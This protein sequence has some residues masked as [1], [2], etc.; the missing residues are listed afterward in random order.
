MASSP[1]WAN[2]VFVVTYDE[3]GGFFDHVAPPRSVAANTVDPPDT[4]GEVLLGMR[5]P[6]IVASPWSRAGAAPRVSSE[7]Y[8]H[9]SILKLIEWRWG[10]P[11]LTAR[12]A[13]G[14]NITNLAHALDLAH[15]DPVVPALPL[16]ATPILAACPPPVAPHDNPWAALQASSLMRRGW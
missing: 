13:P 7:L 3:W 10:V 11:S 9:T 8:D 15:P 12:D 6:V 1:R 2:T 16:L 14:S 5:V 4:N